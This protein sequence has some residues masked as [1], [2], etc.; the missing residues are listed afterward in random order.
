MSII[1]EKHGRLLSSKE[2]AEEL[3]KRAKGIR[4]YTSIGVNRM[5]YEGRLNPVERVGG[6]NFFLPSDV[7]ELKISPNRGN[8]TTRESKGI[9]GTGV[10]RKDLAARA[11]VAQ[12]T[13]W[14]AFQKKPISQEIAGKIH[15]AFNELREEKNLPPMTIGQL[16]WDVIDN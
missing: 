7:A 1:S 8:P 5:V 4:K 9:A 11:G 14:N 3:T 16:G 6:A 10:S 13:V 15:H 2:V 12:T